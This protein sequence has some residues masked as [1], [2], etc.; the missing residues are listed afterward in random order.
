ML[1]G[2]SRFLL[3][4]RTGG[5]LQSLATLV[6]RS[7]HRAVALNVEDLTSELLGAVRLDDSGQTRFEADGGPVPTLGTRLP[8]H[9]KTA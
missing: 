5:N 1:S 3:W 7:C 8:E 4:D 2:A 6:Q 9:R